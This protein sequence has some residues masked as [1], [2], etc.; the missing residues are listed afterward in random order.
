[1]LYLTT[2]TQ[3]RFTFVDRIAAETPLSHHQDIPMKSDRAHPSTHLPHIQLQS[4]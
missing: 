4:T 2:S 3:F 1:M